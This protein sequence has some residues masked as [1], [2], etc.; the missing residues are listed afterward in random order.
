MKVYDWTTAYDGN[1]AELIPEKYYVKDKYGEVKREVERI[2]ELAYAGDLDEEDFYD[3]SL[4]LEEFFEENTGIN[5]ENGYHVYI[6]INR[7]TRKNNKLL[8]VHVINTKL[9]EP[10]Y[11]TG[12]Y[13]FCGSSHDD[14]ELLKK[15]GLIYR[16]VRIITGKSI[17]VNQILSFFSLINYHVK[18]KVTAICYHYYD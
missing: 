1:D 2:K 11:D 9:A 15:Q 16:D 5:S 6:S 13:I 17:T 8:D 3:F 10:G 12:S 7:G 14:I 4:F 18:T